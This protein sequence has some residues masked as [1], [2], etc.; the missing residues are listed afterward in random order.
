MSSRFKLE[1]SE[2]D[3]VLNLAKQIEVGVSSK[4]NKDEPVLLDTLFGG[5][6]AR[7]GDIWIKLDDKICS[8]FEDIK[9]SLLKRSIVIYSIEIYFPVVSCYLENQWG[10]EN[11][12]VMNL[13]IN[14]K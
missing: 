14:N 8:G 3:K 7:Q 13:I 10:T 2:E 4:V 1:S 11:K 5:M 12:G 9:G 6:Y